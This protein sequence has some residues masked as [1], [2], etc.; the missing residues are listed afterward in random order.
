[1]LDELAKKRYKS[2]M[3]R[4]YIQKLN[5]FLYE[6]CIKKQKIT[7]LDIVKYKPDDSVKEN[8]KNLY[9]DMSKIR[10]RNKCTKKIIDENKDKFKSAK[11][12]YFKY[13]E[14]EILTPGNFNFFWNKEN[15]SCQYCGI[16]EKQIECLAQKVKIE[17]K[18]FYSRGKTMEIDKIDA[19]GEYTKDNIILSCYWCNNARTDEFTAAE[20]KLIAKGINEIWNCRLR[21]SGCDDK[22]EFPTKVYE[23]NLSEV[24][25]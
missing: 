14:K 10:E 11:K 3:K 5:Y 9:N 22:I 1:M 21:E 19:F 7:N 12:Q 20:F 25:K 15:R 17:T 23:D 13:Y 6:V 18:R 8:Y 4:N 16:S 24:Y 2:I